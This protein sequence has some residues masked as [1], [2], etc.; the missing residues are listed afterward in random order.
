MTSNQSTHKDGTAY[1]RLMLDSFAKIRKY[2][3]GMSYED[4]IND[5]KTQSA[6]ILQLE[7]IGELAKTV[8]DDIRASIDIPWKDIAG[9][10]DLIAHQYFRLDLATV[11]HTA[12]DS[13]LDVEQKVSEYLK[14]NV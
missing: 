6:V 3:A 7:V 1:L 10:R 2:T 4:F 8:P 11:W 13:V 12:Q 5:G 14:S 9:L